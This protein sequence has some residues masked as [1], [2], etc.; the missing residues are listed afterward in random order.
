MFCFF[1]PTPRLLPE[2]YCRGSWHTHTHTPHLR[3]TSALGH[4][5][6]LCEG[7]L[8]ACREMRGTGS[9]GRLGC[10]GR[11]AVFV[12]GEGGSPHNLDSGGY[13]AVALLGLTQISKPDHQIICADAGLLYL[14]FHI[15]CQPLSLSSCFLHS[16]Y[17]C[18]SLC[19]FNKGLYV[20]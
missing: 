12:L 16:V 15:L 17:L 4:P 7:R 18:I 6:H 14:P 8:Q 5:P 3:S 2:G 9:T 10:M 20:P 13:M 11:K 1:I 19:G